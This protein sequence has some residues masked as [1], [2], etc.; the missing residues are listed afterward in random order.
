MI[1]K[2]GLPVSNIGTLEQTTDQGGKDTFLVS[3]PCLGKH[4]L[5]VQ[6][7]STPS[8]L[9]YG[10]RQFHILYRSY[11]LTDLRVY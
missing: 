3:L 5:P 6:N 2:L 8:A 11:F 4:M 10:N 7:S 9:G 1:S